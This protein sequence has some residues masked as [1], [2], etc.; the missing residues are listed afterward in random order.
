MSRRP[1]LEALTPRVTHHFGALREG[2]S[3]HLSALQATDWA[4]AA[5]EGAVSA[6]SSY[7][8]TAHDQLRRRREVDHHLHLQPARQ[9]PQRRQA[10][11]LTRLAAPR[12]A[13]TR[14]ARLLVAWS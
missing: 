12:Q 10:R 11:R 6:V 3:S 1:G 13:G 8:T 7:T 4:G 9:R 2:L 14:T 5:K